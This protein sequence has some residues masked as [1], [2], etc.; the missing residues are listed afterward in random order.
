MN[1]QTKNT[2][3]ISLLA[4]GVIGAVILAGSNN[5]NNANAV[6][7]HGHSI[8]AADDQK[9]APSLEELVGK[10][11]PTFSLTDIN[12][13]VYSSDSLKG[14]NVVLFFNEGLMCYPACWNQISA[15]GKDARF[16]SEDTI[17]LS[18]V[19]DPKK[20]WGQALEKMPE[21]AAAKT[22]F[23]DGGDVSRMFNVLKTPSS[24]HY[25]SLPGHTYI[26]IDKAGIVRYVLD[27]PRMAIRN[28]E[29]FAKISA[30]NK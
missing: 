25:G 13:T 9:N 8:A 28:D 4:V 30:F 7:G 1:S 2:V 24:M 16:N 3:I 19:V 29:I 18:V 6:D 12:G 26:V 27:D 11:V 20:D 21:L 10:P 22:L 14:K 15:F 23:D 17:A 5:A